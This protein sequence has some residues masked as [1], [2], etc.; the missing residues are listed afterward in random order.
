MNDN[1]TMQAFRRMFPNWDMM[2]D[3]QRKSAMSDPKLQGRIDAEKDFKR[4][5]QGRMYSE[6]FRNETE[7]RSPK[8]MSAGAASYG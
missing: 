3:Q 1:M 8:V 2:T 7:R 4:R 6:A 5:E